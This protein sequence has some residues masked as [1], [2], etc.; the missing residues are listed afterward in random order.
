MRTRKE[1]IFT[2]IEL[3]VVIAIIAILAG[4]LLP[5]L[6]S[7]REKARRIACTN[8]LKQI[9][10]AAKQYSNDF[11]EKFPCN[12]TYIS[13][14][15][16][17]QAS[18]AGPHGAASMTLLMSQNYNTDYKTYV[19]PSSTLNG[20]HMAG[21]S[22]F[23]NTSTGY[24]L[25]VGDSA[26]NTNLSYGLIAGMNENDAADSGLSFDV[27]IDKASTKSNHDKYGNILY[28]DGHVSGH[29]GDSWYSNIKFYGTNVSTA[30][31]V[32]SMSGN[33]TPALKPVNTMG[34]FGE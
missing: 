13:A 6:N 30:D 22:G 24:C 12:S 26:T 29:A 9:G 17:F 4:M 27:A 34:T 28:I 20:V 15:N 3:L 11:N 14:A 2:L 33:A 18:G 5:A 7:A 16:G 31:T 8:N 23:A 19:C 1:S 32:P 10:L 25:T 21:K